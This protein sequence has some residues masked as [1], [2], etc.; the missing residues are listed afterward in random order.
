MKNLK[1][2]LMAF[3]A[4]CLTTSLQAQKTKTK[5]KSKTS[6]ASSAVYAC[7]MKCE[8]DKTYAKAGDCPVCGMHLK[9]VQKTTAYQCP[10]K[11]EGDKTY[12]K[13]GTCPVCNMKLKAVANKKEQKSEANHPHK[14]SSR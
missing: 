8:G 1:F 14:H 12:A 7:P 4:L 13:D 2:L 10:M 9:A 3:M 11:C 5:T 6:Q